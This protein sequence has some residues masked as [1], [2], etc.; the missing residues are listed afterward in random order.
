MSWKVYQE[1]D[2]YGDN[3]L[4]HFANFRGT[5]EATPLHDKA[6]RWVDGSNAA[7]AKTSNGEHLAAAFRHDVETGRLPSVSWI[8]AAERLTEHPK[9]SP[10]LGQNLVA[11]LLS[12]LADNPQVFAKTVFIL[13]YDENDGFFDHVPPPVP[14]T[15]PAFGGSTVST[16]AARTY[17]TEPVGLGP[18]R[19][20]DRDLALDQEGGFVNSQLFD[21]TSVIRLL[22]TRFGVMEPNISPWRRAVCGDMTSVFDFTGRDATIAAL[23]AAAPWS[24]GPR[25]N[26]KLAGPVIDFNPGQLPRQEPSRRLTLSPAPMRCLRCTGRRQRATPWNWS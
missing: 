20:D 21:H 23:P 14:A 15:D 17:G 1:F 9:G 12:A 5:G 24:A 2:N 7:N 26:I 11:Q 8:V 3:S 6:R 10:A 16:A 22:E 25:P 4:A 13:N 19:A 18:A